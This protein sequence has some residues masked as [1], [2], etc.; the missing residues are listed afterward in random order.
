MTSCTCQ[1]FNETVSI[2]TCNQLVVALTV[3]QDSH[4]CNNLSWVQA[5]L[6]SAVEAWSLQEVIVE[7]GSLHL[8]ICLRDGPTCCRREGSAHR[9]TD[10]AAD[11]CANA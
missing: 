11:L 6:E 5:V 3:L 1:S 8:Q 10:S 7:S 9:V 4:M 2:S